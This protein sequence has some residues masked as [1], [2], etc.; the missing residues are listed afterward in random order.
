MAKVVPVE[1][2][3]GLLECL[4]VVPARLRAATALFFLASAP[5]HGTWGAEMIESREGVSVRLELRG[6]LERI[7]KLM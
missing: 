3:Q 6:S 2:V 1:A 5:I 7:R 4:S